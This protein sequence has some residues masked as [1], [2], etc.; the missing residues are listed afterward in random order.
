MKLEKHREVLKEVSDTIKDAL[1]NP[2]GMVYHQRRL[3]AMLSLGVSQLL[4]TY[5]HKLN[6]I[7]PGT[8]IK[9]EWFKR[10]EDNILLRLSAVLTTAPRDIPGMDEILAF[11]RRVESER[12]D[13]VY[14]SPLANDKKLRE[15]IDLWLELKKLVDE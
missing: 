11:A 4:E 6:V 8:Q 13:I 12:D 3:M 5:F 9:H 10:S 14:G 7:K 1:E 2:E 15:K